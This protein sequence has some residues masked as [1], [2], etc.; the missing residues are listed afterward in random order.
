MSDLADCYAATVARPDG[1]GPRDRLV[2]DCEP[3]HR[4]ANS[5]ETADHSLVIGDF[6]VTNSRSKQARP[7]K[8][9]LRGS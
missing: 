9:T 5:A 3:S 2:S 6:G 1:Q 7:N 8:R 4:S